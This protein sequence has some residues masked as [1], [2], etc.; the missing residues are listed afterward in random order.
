[1]SLASLRS[2]RIVRSDECA[3]RAVELHDPVERRDL[4]RQQPLPHFLEIVVI[5]Q[6]EHAAGMHAASADRF[7]S[8]C[9]G[10]MACGASNR[11]L[12]ERR[13]MVPSTPR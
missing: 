4:A 10:P 9:V 5:P 7:V 1:M 8:S 3:A 2:A 6:V 11:D 12:A 13:P